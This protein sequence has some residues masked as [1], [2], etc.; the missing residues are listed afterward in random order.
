MCVVCACVYQSNLI[1]C[2]VNK[3]EENLFWLS[4]LEQMF[5]RNFTNGDRN[6]NYTEVHLWDTD[7]TL[8]N[9]VS[10]YGAAYLLGLELFL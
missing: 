10:A 6:Q 7:E 4:D 8:Q 1:L 2:C 3:Y 5:R 9:N